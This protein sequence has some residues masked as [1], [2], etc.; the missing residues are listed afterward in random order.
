VH[1]VEEEGRIWKYSVES[2]L[3]DADTLCIFGKLVEW[4]MAEADGAPC[5]ITPSGI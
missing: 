2:P 1:F 5:R 4:R 3:Q